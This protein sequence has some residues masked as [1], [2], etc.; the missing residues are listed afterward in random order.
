MPDERHKFHETS[1]TLFVCGSAK[2][3]CEIASVEVVLRKWD[4][5][6]HIQRVHNESPDIKSWLMRL[7]LNV[8]VRLRLGSD[9][10]K[11]RPYVVKCSIEHCGRLGQ[12]ALGFAL[13]RNCRQ[14]ISA[15]KGFVTNLLPTTALVLI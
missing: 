10:L 6:T 7:C 8:C 2:F 9:G 15:L 1:P 4:D 14:C 3:S 13:D 12:T 5:T 11:S